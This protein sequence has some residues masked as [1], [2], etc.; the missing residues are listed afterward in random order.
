MIVESRDTIIPTFRLPAPSVRVTESMV[1]P[2]GLEPPTSHS[3]QIF[4]GSVLVHSMN[5]DN[6]SVQ[7]P[8]SARSRKEGKV[9]QWRAVCARR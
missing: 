7:G 4:S 6:L 8:N 5:V 9:V 2:G 1:G 3:Q